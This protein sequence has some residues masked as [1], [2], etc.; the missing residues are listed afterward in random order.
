MSFSGRTR[1]SF[2]SGREEARKAL[3]RVCG[4][5]W[6]SLDPFGW[7]TALLHLVRG[8]KGE[9]FFGLVSGLVARVAGAEVSALVAFVFSSGCERVPTKR[10]SPRPNGAKLRASNGTPCDLKWARK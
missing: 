3:F 1:S 10:A 5:K 4:E 9:S 2:R 6:V 8:V 7:S